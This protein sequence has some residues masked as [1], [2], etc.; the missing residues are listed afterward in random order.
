MSLFNERIVIKNEATNEIN[1]YY[2]ATT[3]SEVRSDLLYAI[4]L[5]NEPKIAIDCGCG[6]G[7]DIEY[8]LANNFFVY[9]FDIEEESIARCKKRF[10]NNHNVALSQASFSSYA[11]PQAS[12]IVADASLFFCPKTDFVAVWNSINNAL[13]SD[14]I[15]FG[16]FLGPKDT[17]A[18]QDYDGSAFW[19]DILVLTETE[20]KA[21]FKSYQICRFTEHK[22]S[23]QT[24]DGKAHS[25]HIFSVVV[26]KIR[27]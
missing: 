25:W 19:S 12:L 23:A 16:S 10:E 18:T 7:A 13:S 4:T 17:M 1:Q 2:D 11:Y 6:A 22:S 24:P 8:L 5:V 26:K 3:N 9:G 21:L 14:G 20:I 15:F 27:Q